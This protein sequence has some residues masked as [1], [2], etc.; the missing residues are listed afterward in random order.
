[1]IA[2]HFLEFEFKLVIVQIVGIEL[3]V[4][5]ISPHGLVTGARAL[6]RI[7]LRGR[8]WPATAAVANEQGQRIGT[9]SNRLDLTCDR[10]NHAY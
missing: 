3:D 7:H 8:C 10:E 6:S 5:I 1:M 4:M 9:R 2:S